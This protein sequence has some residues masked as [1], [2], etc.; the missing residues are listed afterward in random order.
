MQVELLCRGCACRVAS[1]AYTAAHQVLERLAAEG[2]WSAL[3]DG[4][5][6]EDRLCADLATVPAV[7]CP[8]CG[9]PLDVCEESL[10]E[11]TA[12]LLAHW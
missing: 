5:T 12:E 3:G 10:S 1:G 4:E 6:F 11:F 2:P 9:A 7:S 8:E